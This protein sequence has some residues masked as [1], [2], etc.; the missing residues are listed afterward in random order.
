MKAHL[1]EAI[2]LRLCDTLLG[3]RYIEVNIDTNVKIVHQHDT[4]LREEGAFK[5]SL[6]I[7][8]QIKDVKVKPPPQKEV[9]I[10]R[11]QVIPFTIIFV[12]LEKRLCKGQSQDE[13]KK[14]IGKMSN[15]T[16]TLEAAVLVELNRS[17]KKKQTALQ[18]TMIITKKGI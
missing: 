3:S 10:R 2:K 5:R 8:L 12:F 16:L 11:Y 6:T 15:D 17:H 1:P 13:P 4:K 18:T 7:P 14:Y 9:S